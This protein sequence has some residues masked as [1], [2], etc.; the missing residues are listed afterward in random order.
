MGTCAGV[1]AAETRATLR[2]TK[3]YQP[4][5]AYE[6]AMIATPYCQC[7]GCPSASNKEEKMRSRAE[8]E[9]RGRPYFFL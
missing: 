4:L 9:R 1:L 6:S 3:T 5:E 2:N 7:D 8:T